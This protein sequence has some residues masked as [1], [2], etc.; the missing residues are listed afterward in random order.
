MTIDPVSVS[1]PALVAIVPFA[2]ESDGTVSPMVATL[3][4]NTASAWASLADGWLDVEV[5]AKV[6]TGARIKISTRC[7]G[8]ARH[9]MARSKRAVTLPVRRG[10]SYC[11]TVQS[12]YRRKISIEIR[13]VSTVATAK[14]QGRNKTRARNSAMPG[15]MGASV[16]ILTLYT[17]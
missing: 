15:N 11:S 7:K 6:M 13:E 9:F 14:S 1:P 2:V 4:C 10:D 3:C 5:C 17:M 16:K 8:S 12:W